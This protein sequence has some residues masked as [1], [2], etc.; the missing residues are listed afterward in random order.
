[1]VVEHDEE[2]IRRADHVIDL[3]PGAGSR[4]GHVVGSGTVQDLMANPDSLTG[5][6]LRDPLR[7]PQVPRRAVVTRGRSATPM[8]RVKGATL[9]NLNDLDVDLPLGRII[10][11]TGVSGSGKSTLARD[12]LFTE[13][14]SAIGEAQ[15]RSPQYTS[16]HCDSLSGYEHIER[17]LEVDQTPIGRTPRSCPATYVGFW[18]AIRKVYAAAS[19]V[20]HPRLHGQPV[21]VQHRR[22][23][24]RS[25][26]RPGHTHHRHELPARRESAVRCL[27]WAALRSGDPVAYSGG[28]NPSA[29]CWP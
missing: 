12:V 29:M 6:Y 11:L 1:M 3:G 19:E 17:V 18:D 14:R 22:R 10:A 20:G 27:Q 26:R 28:E 7:H 23:S 21:L 24:L 9:H 2:T 13:L 4:G 16:R 15:R 5:R 8:L 25:L